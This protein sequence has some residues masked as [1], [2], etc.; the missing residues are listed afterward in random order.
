MTKIG[1]SKEI[2]LWQSFYIRRYYLTREFQELLFPEEKRNDL[3]AACNEY[4]YLQ[5]KRQACIS[6]ERKKKLWTNM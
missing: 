4:F 2:F 3:D 6:E 1:K 5:K